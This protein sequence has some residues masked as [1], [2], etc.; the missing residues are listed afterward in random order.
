M[1][2]R[3]NVKRLILLVIRVSAD[4]AHLASLIKSIEKKAL[5]IQL[6]VIDAVPKP[7][8]S[9]RPHDSTT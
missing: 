8:A 1:Q 6:V 3:K 9:K 4:D 2:V 5:R 7:S